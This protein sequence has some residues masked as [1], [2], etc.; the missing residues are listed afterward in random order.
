[1]VMRRL[2][3]AAAISVAA[4][5]A[6][7]VLG[8]LRAKGLAVTLDPDGL[9]RY[10]QLWTFTLHAGTVAALGLGLGTT[11]F[12]AAARERAD[13]D[14]LATT[15]SIALLIPAVAGGVALVVVALAADV[16]ARVLVGSGATTALLIAALSIPLVAMQLPLQHLL[17]GFEDVRG[18]AAAYTSYSL[19]FTVTAVG[20]AAVGGVEGAAAGLTLGNLAL[21]LLYLLRARRLL[22]TFGTSARFVLARSRA[23]LRRP[24]ARTLFKI[25]AASLLVAAA[26]AAA[27]LLVRTILLHAA[28]VADAGVWHGMSIVSVQFVGALTGALTY[29]ATP[30]LARVAV[31]PERALEQLVMDDTLRLVLAGVAPAIVAIT[32][33]RSDFVAL[34]F[35][36][37]FAAM[38]PLI[39]LLMAGDL[40]RTIAWSLGTALIPLGRTRAWMIIGIG[41]SVV[42]AGI[43]TVA[44]SA[45][46]LRGVTSSYAAMWAFALL[47]TAATL[48]GASAWRPTRQTIVAAGGAA[49]ALAAAVLVPGPKGFV[50]ALGIL[51]AALAA[52]ARPSE[53]AFALD[54][55]RGA[56]RRRS[57]TE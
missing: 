19:L 2:A 9:G 37:D 48:F 51:A 50:L 29:F 12:V 25:G 55:L 54:L 14:A 5:A 53:R 26:A 57:S 30:L 38:T 49:A 56:T 13:E 10:G 24:V 47:A 31:T 45:W 28:G 16:L 32:A 7:A 4:A 40:L 3:S 15:T 27:D 46:G 39:P 33:F 41:T 23:A 44:A 42:F 21:A 8:W 6:S 20:G 43:G 11:R 1:M 17:Q 35:D 36:A 22:E 18:Q 52:V 34:A